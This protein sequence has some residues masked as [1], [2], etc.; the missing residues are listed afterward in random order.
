MVKGSVINKEKG[1][2]KK[3]FEAKTKFPESPRKKFVKPKLWEL[4]WSSSALLSEMNSEMNDEMKQIKEVVKSVEGLS[5]DIESANTSEGKIF[6][7]RLKLERKK[8]WSGWWKYR[9]IKI[10]PNKEGFCCVHYSEIRADGRKYRAAHARAVHGLRD[11]FHTNYPT[12]ISYKYKSFFKKVL[13]EF[14]K[15]ERRQ[16]RIY[17]STNVGSLF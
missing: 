8:D 10:Y 1:Y 7:F 6:R 9:T 12:E 13:E 3:E 17:G 14:V 16:I 11:T 5:V 2:A 4:N 15:E